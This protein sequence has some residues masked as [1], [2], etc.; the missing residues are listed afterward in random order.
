[1]KLTNYKIYRKRLTNSASRKIARKRRRWFVI[2]MLLLAIGVAATVVFAL[3]PA[4][5]ERVGGTTI[6]VNN[7][8]GDQV[9]LGVDNPLFTNFLG[10]NGSYIATPT[11]TP[12]PNGKIAFVSYRDG[13]PEIY[14]M[15]A[16]G[17]NQINLHNHPAEGNAPAISPDRSKIAFSSN[18]DAGNGNPD[19]YV[20]NA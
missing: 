1:M 3:T 19:I 18:R 11:P 6:M 20:M 4:N 8:A 16:D 14:V 5:G 10:V 9:D 7:S 15:N 2:S 12:T 13:N 17:S